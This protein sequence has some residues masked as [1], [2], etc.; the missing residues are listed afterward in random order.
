MGG[1]PT[2]GASGDAAYSPARV[3]NVTDGDIDNRLTTHEESM[4]FLS[5]LDADSLLTYE[6]DETEIA[7][8]VR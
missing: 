3:V 6:Y 4:G 1:Q 5:A 7:T 8:I 2:I